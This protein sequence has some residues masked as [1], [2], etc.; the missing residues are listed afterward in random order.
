MEDIVALGIKS[1]VLF[2]IPSKKDGFG[3][4][5]FDKDGITQQ[6]I[7]T[8]KD[9]FGEK[10]VVITDVCLC[11]YT[12]HGHCGIIKNNKVDNDRTLD[13]LAKI[14]LSHATLGADMVAPSADDGWPGENIERHSR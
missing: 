5:A 2:G 3:N 14:A 12:S 13:T 10:L 7:K 11:Q 9:T 4:S 8:I 1:I 6:A